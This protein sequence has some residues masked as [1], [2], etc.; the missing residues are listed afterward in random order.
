MGRLIASLRSCHSHPIR[1]SNS[2]PRTWS[3]TPQASSS[4]ALTESVAHAELTLS[5]FWRLFPSLGKLDGQG[6]T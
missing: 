4:Q 5:W 6:T 3:G 2:S 1:V